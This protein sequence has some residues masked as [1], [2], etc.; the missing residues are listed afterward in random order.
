MRLAM[1]GWSGRVSRPERGFTLIEIVLAL[2][3][4]GLIFIMVFFAVAQAQKARR[5]TQRK[6]D[7]AAFVAAMGAYAAEH[8]LQTPQ[9]GTQLNAGMASFYPNRKDPSTGVAYVGDF[10][11]VGAPHDLGGSMPAMGHIAFVQGH[12]CGQDTG[13]SSFV[14]DPPSSTPTYHAFAALLQLEQSQVMYCITGHN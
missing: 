13:A 7:L 11:N 14:D 9:D 1:S 3:I 5:D 2:A 6:Q 10:W 4:A 12:V 8:Q